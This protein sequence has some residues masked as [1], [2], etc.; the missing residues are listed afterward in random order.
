[1]VEHG[2]GPG[3]ARMERTGKTV[4][5][6]REQR[7]LSEKELAKRVGYADPSM[8]S[9]IEAGLKSPSLEK[10]QD[11]AVH[12]GVTLSQLVGET[13][14]PQTVSMAATGDHTV[15]QNIAGR[16]CTMHVDAVVDRLEQMLQTALTEMRQ[17]LARPG[18]PA[19]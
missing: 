7:T 11:L 18:P 5:M 14:A 3:R 12:L 6:Y 15:I 17:L 13:P 1:M 19:A 9:Q 16:Y 4:R 2:Q 8:I 10:A